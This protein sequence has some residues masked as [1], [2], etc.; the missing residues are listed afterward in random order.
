[1]VQLS[2]EGMQVPDRP[3]LLVRVFLNKPDANAN[4]PFQ[5]IHYAGN[6]SFFTAGRPGAHGPHGPT[7]QLIDV[8]GAIARLTAA[9]E[10]K[11]GGPLTV[12]LVAR[13]IAGVRAA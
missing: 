12:T 1:T 5:D 13:P 11:P 4:T 10:Y 9:N 2:I 6:F 3:Q 7:T 8:T